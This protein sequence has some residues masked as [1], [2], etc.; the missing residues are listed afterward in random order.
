MKS[1][2]KRLMPAVLVIVI[3]SMILAGCDKGDNDGEG[4]GEANTLEADRPEFIKSETESAVTIIDSL[5]NEV[6][7]PKNP[8]RVVSLY[9]SYTDLWYEAGG[10]ITAGVS[11][12]SFPVPE[13]AED[14]G[15]MSKISPEK[16]LALRPGLV[17]MGVNMDSQVAL[18]DMLED[19]KIPYLYVEYNLYEDYVNNLDLMSRLNG[20][21]EQ[22]AVKLKAIEDKINSIIE[23]VKGKKAPRVLIM[24]A[25]SKSVSCEVS[26]GTTG[27]MLELLGGVNIAG[28]SP[29]EGETR[30][31][32]SMES[33]AVGDPDMIFIKTMGKVESC[34]ELIKKEIE[35]NEAWAAMRAVKEGR[36]YYLD[37]DLFLSKPN[38]RFPEAF[39][40]LAGY[41]Y[42]DK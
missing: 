5:G 12:K 31:D 4:A 23:S 35:S 41:M 7:L 37:K 36:I 6:V 24:F 19:N 34:K 39:D 3:I 27:N 33:I 30:V 20:T 25:T 10:K 1:L 13:G 38:E 11:S 15:S 26:A 18:K 16:I 29:I 28:D 22:V 14:L 9:A 21:E 2:L 42:Q 32:F 40:I 8:E 17:I